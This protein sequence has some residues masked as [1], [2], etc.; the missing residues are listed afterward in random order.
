MAQDQL[1]LF[2]LDPV[3][4]ITPLDDYQRPDWDDLETPYCCDCK[5]WRATENQRNEEGRE[6]L[7]K[8]GPGSCVLRKKL[9][10][11]STG[12]CSKWGAGK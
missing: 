2:E 9:T 7:W 3:A 5:N 1:A 10:T 12:Y 6:E 4:I 8:S 11:Y